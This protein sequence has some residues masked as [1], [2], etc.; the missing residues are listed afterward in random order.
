MKVKI[1]A[2]KTYKTEVNADKAVA[3]AGFQAFR[4]FMMITEDGRFFPVFTDQESIRE[5][6]HFTFNVL[7][8]GGAK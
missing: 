2:S 1:V 5:G 6:I 8:T 7:L 4:H 3:A